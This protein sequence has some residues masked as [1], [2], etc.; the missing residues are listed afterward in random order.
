MVSGAVKGFETG[1]APSSDYDNRMYSI[2]DMSQSRLFRAVFKR[3]HK[4]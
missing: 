2:A 3:K 1:F 4:I